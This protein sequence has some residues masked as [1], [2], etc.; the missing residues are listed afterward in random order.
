VLAMA[1]IT[2]AAEY[3]LVREAIQT[4]STAGTRLASFTVDGQSYSYAA[5]Q[6]P[7]LYKREEVLAR[8]L[9]TRNLRKRT[10]PDFSYN[11]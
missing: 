8:R 6:L 7:Q 11:A 10:T 1:A 5:D 2:T 3:Q 9:C 4:L